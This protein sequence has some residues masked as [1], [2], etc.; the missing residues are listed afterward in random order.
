MIRAQTKPPNPLVWEDQIVALMGTS[1]RFDSWRGTVRFHVEGQWAILSFFPD[2]KG[3]AQAVELS[4]APHYRSGTDDDRT[5]NPLNSPPARGLTR[6]N[7]NAPVI[8]SGHLFHLEDQNRTSSRV[9]LRQRYRGTID[10]P[11]VS[12]ATPRYLAAFG[13]VELAQ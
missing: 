12:V 10:N 4:T 11:S 9:G 13:H 2:C 8:V 3:L 7:G 6:V 1:G 5:L